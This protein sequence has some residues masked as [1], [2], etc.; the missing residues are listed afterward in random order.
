LG[1]RA[2]RPTVPAGG[3][4]MTFEYIDPLL[5]K[6]KEDK[7]GARRDYRSS[8][9]KG[10]PGYEPSSPTLLRDWLSLAVTFQIQA[11]WFSKDDLPLPGLEN[12]VQGEHDFRAPFMPA[13]SWRGLLHWAARMKTGQRARLEANGNMVKDWSDSAEVV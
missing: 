1:R 10:H 12:A 2:G 8:A 9:P 3:D 11:P 6:L 5:V 7:D 4:A 13:S